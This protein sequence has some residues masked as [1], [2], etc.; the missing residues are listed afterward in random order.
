MRA[1]LPSAL[2]RVMPRRRETN[3][4]KHFQL[5]I[6]GKQRVQHRVERSGVGND[7]HALVPA[8]A[9]IV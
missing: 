6:A 5:R 8:C 3:G 4:A 2:K 1:S 9:Q 7:Q